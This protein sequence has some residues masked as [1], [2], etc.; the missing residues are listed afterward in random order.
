MDIRITPGPL[1]GTVPAPV[2]KSELH[3][4]LICSSFSDAPVMIKGFT[5]RLPDDILATVSC[6]ERLGAVISCSGGE[7]YVTPVNKV[8]E[9]PLLDCAESGSTLRFLLPVTAAVCGSAEIH[10]DSS[11]AARPVSELIDALSGC[12]AGFTSRTLP[13]ELRSSL[14]GNRFLIPGNVSSQYV[15]GLMMASALLPGTSEVAVTT[16]LVSRDYVGMTSEIMR[17]FGAAVE[18]TESLFRI[19]G[20][21]RSPGT[22][23]AGGDWS[24][25]AAVMAAAAASPGSDVTVTGLEER[26]HQADR[27]IA[28]ILSSMGALVSIDGG[29][30]RVKSAGKLRS[31]ELDADMIPDLFPVTAALGAGAEGVS[32][33]RNCRRLRYKES[34]RI[35]T[36]DRLLSGFGTEVSTD[37]ERFLVTGPGGRRSAEADPEGDHRIAMAAAVAAYAVG[38]E[39]VIRGAECVEK[40]YPA[41]FD[42]LRSLGGRVDVI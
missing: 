26:S 23:A 12:G 28:G 39:T 25:A 4:M 20:P 27:R 11:L 7:I 3:R 10:G 19:S 22:A 32:E 1:K 2:S 13:T 15:S 9:R 14:S 31:A 8:P 16:P 17:E 24:G 30:V 33:F 29:S 6:L 34:D 37:G 36:M 21:Y 41:F 5:G 40:S 35:R 18:Q 38:A 42:D